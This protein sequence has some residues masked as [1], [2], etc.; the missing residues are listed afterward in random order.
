VYPYP[1]AVFLK[2]PS[3]PSASEGLVLR[4]VAPDSVQRLRFVVDGREVANVGRPFE[5]VL[6]LSRGFH[7]VWAE[8]GQG[9]RSETV[10]FEVR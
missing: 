7:Q 1:G 8:T 5:Q 9:G 4:A 2:D 3:M 10:R 6:Q